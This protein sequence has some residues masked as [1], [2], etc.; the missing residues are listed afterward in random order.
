METLETLQ[1]RIGHRVPALFATAPDECVSDRYQFVRTADYVSALLDRGWT[2]TRA[3]QTG[4]SATGL[5][6]VEMRHPS[7]RETANNLGG[8]IPQML[9]TNAHNATRALRVAIGILRKVCTNGLVVAAGP[10]QSIRVRHVGDVGSAADLITEQFLAQIEAHIGSAQQWSEIKLDDV[11]RLQFA[12]DAWA[13]RSNHDENEV[14][15]DRFLDWLLRPR[16]PEDVGTDLWRVFNVLQERVTY[17]VRAIDRNMKMNQSLWQLAAE[18]YSR[19][20]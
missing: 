9:L 12:R 10:A 13:L 8:L 20:N 14:V 3:S 5:H 18:I 15:N 19:R 11:E 1:A 4:R 7:M 17:S 2:V 16:R 6:L